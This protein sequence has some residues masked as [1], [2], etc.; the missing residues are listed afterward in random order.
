M[1]RAIAYRF[2]IRDLSSGEYVPGGTIENPTFVKIG[3]KKVTR[4]DIFGKVAGLSGNEF[5]LQDKTGKITVRMFGDSLQVRELAI[6]N[7]V[8]VIGKI[9]QDDRGRY[10]LGEIIKRIDDANYQLLR[11][12][13]LGAP[14]VEEVSF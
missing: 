7:L 14:L 1:K 10:V 12:K 2:W 6:G 4:V 8:R 9:R 11:E 13:E 5:V 3:E